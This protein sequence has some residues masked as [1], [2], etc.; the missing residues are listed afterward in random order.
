MYGPYE[1]VK[2]GASTTESDNALWNELKKNKSGG[3]QASWALF[4][5]IDNFKS[6]TVKASYKYFKLENV[7]DHIKTYI[8][9]FNR[10]FQSC[11]LSF[12]V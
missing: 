11:L 8:M 5:V 7:D 1:N 2:W 6:S 9:G 10:E 4:I 12:T 3:G